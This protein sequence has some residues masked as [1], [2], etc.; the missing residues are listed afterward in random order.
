MLEIGIGTLLTAHTQDHTI[1]TYRLGKHLA[2]FD[3]EGE[4]FLQVDVFL[5]IAGIDSHEGMPV[6]GGSDHH[7]INIF[8]C[9]KILVILVGLHGHLLTGFGITGIHPLQETF[10]FHTVDITAGY[11]LYTLHAEITGKQIHRLLTQS[12]KTK[13][14]NTVARITGCFLVL[15]TGC[16][17][18]REQCHTGSTHGCRLEKFSSC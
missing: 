8:P 6:V 7:G 1:V 9:D 15:G 16:Q 12:D 5:R 18:L 14:E 4:R 2:L 11:N 10:P 17:E 3:S 13:A